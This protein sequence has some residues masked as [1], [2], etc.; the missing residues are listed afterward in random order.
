M[1]DTIRQGEALTWQGHFHVRC[2]D[3]PDGPLLW[4]AEAHNLIT[5]VGKGALLSNGLA[6]AAY[7]AAN[8]VGIMNGATA[9]TTSASDT[10]TSHSGWQES[11][12]AVN[13]TYTGPRKSGVFPA[14]TTGTITMNPVTLAMTAAGT[15]GG[16]FVCGF[17]GATGTIDNTGGVLFNGATFAAGQPVISGNSVTISYGATLS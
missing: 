5:T 14:T 8:Y 12:N 2:T 3:G 17:S 1:D 16:M 10:M 13:P 9:I 7:T 6:G 4:E 11:G 15:I